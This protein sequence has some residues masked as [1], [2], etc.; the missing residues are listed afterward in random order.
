[1]QQNGL[2]TG[3][4]R[5]VLEK[6]LGRDLLSASDINN[7]VGECFSENQIYRIDH[8][9]GKETVQNLL[10]LRFANS[11]FEPLWRRGAVDHV[12]ITVA[13][14]LGVGGRIEFSIASV[15]YATWSKTTCC[16]W[17]A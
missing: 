10:A 7:A 9:L 12:Q 13:E 6:P 1:M 15:H 2:I 8:Y 3:N 16:N 4:S 11:L 17:S 5:I 14:D